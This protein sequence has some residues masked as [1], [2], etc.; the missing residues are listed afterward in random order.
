MGMY[1]EQQIEQAIECIRSFSTKLSAQIE[2]TKSSGDTLETNME[3]DVVAKDKASKLK[4]ALDEVQDVLDTN[5][6]SI[7][8]KLENEKSRAAGIASDND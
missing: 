4:K 8:S 2:M 1:S 5:V 3:G 7:I 6:S